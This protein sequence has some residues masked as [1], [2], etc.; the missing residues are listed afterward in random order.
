M[1]G[2]LHESFY[3]PVASGRCMIVGAPFW[4]YFLA[5]VPPE[6]EVAPLITAIRELD[7]RPFRIISHV[8]ES[9]KVF[10]ASFFDSSETM[11]RFLEW[12]DANALTPGGE[13]HSCLASAAPAGGML[14]TPDSLLFGKG[15]HALADTRFGEYQLGM[16][17][18]YSHYQLRDQEMLEETRREAAKPEFEERIAACMQDHAVSY[19]GRLIMEQPLP[20]G[21]AEILTAARYG[22]I[23]DARR[24]SAL[25]RELLGPEMRRWF[26]SHSDLLGT[27]TRVLE[28]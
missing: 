11:S 21:G 3:T 8:D 12:Y 26:A 28:L 7:V 15:V 24:G 13:Y 10:N 19:F 23:D 4:R 22:S 20:D 1:P 16:A 6:P 14:P 17:V 27:A 5:V 25:S 9:G 18:R 2:H